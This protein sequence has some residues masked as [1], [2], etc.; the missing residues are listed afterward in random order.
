MR[1]RSHTSRWISRSVESPRNRMR[2]RPPTRLVF[3][4]SS[5]STIGNSLQRRLNSFQ[6]WRT[7]VGCHHTCTA[8]K[9]VVAAHSAMRC[10]L[11][12]CW[13]QSAQESI[14]PACH[15]PC[16]VHQPNAPAACRTG[17]GHALWC[18]PSLRSMSRARHLRTGICIAWEPE[19]ILYR[20]KTLCVGPSQ[21]VGLLE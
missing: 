3:E 10:V 7:P 16:Q 11:L 4:L 19:S 1:P 17:S 5:L 12:C 13:V 6:V 21:V 9:P 8:S 15:P 2:A 18:I 14:S 20:S